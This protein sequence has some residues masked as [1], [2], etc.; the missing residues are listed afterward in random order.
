MTIADRSLNI[1]LVEDD[2]VDVMNVRRAF[3][4][5]GIASQL[6]VAANGLEALQMLRGGQVPG[7]R[8]LV[9]L[10]LN[11]PR[12]NGIEFLRHV[13]SDPQLNL[14]PVVVLTTSADE[15]DKIS[16]FNLNV[17]GYLVK[18]VTFG[19]FA[20]LMATLNKYWTLVEFP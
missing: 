18:P 17:A 7:E 16:A 19:A 11:M 3:E 13:R 15:R 2:A 20:E 14:I 5:N 6:H 8:R 1:L 10:D 9:L 4:K 12:M